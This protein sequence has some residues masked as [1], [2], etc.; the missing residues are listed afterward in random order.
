MALEQPIGQIFKIDSTRYEVIGV[1]KDFHIYSFYD[2]MRST[3]FKVADREDYR[4]LSMRVRSGSEKE[5][6]EVLQAQWAA[7][8]PETPFQGGHQEDI[9]SWY[10]ENVDTAERFMQVVAFIAVLLASL[11]LYGLVML[12]VSGR[13]K[14]FSIRKILGAGIKNITANIT[15]Q[16]MILSAVA[17]II[18]APVSYVLTKAHLNMLYAYPMPMSYSGVALSMV[19]LIFVLLAVVSIQI[20]KVSTSNP[21]DGLKVE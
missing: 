10:F 1:V 13:V 3:I 7:L 9:F 5:T 4:Y 8:F 17:L 12:N 18:G 20:T 14:E 2:E 16:Y 6:Y 11:G 21:V 15:K 19:M